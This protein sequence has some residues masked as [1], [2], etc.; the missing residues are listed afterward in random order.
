MSEPR[1]TIVGLRVLGAFL[2]TAAVWFIQPESEVRAAAAIVM[3]FN[4]FLAATII[5][6][7]TPSPTE[8]PK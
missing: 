1:G 4:C 5:R 7:L 2:C 6:V 3:G 8:P